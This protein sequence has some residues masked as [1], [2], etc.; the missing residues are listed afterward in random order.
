MPS[1]ETISTKEQWYDLTQ[2]KSEIQNFV[3]KKRQQLDKHS[4]MQ[5]VSDALYRICYSGSTE[6]ERERFPFAAELFKVYK[7]ALIESSL[8][9]YSALVEVNGEDAQNVLKAPKV[10]EA[11]TL[12]LKAMSM[13]EKISGEVLD[14]WCFKGE[15]AGIIKL[16]DTK[17][18]YRVK[19]EITNEE[20]GQKEMTFK[21]KE[22]VEYQDIGIDFIDPLDLYIDGLDYEKDPVGCTKIIRSFIDAKKL[23]S[24]NAYPLLTK[25]DKE[26]II[27]G[28]GRNGNGTN[29]PWF[30]WAGSFS[31]VSNS[32]EV[33]DKNQIEVLTFNGDYVTSDLKVLNNIQAVLVGNRIAN[34]RYNTVSTNRIIYAAYKLDRTTHRSISPLAV[35]LPTNKLVN[36]VTDMFIKNLDEVS[37]PWL[38]YAKGTMNSNQIAEARRKRELEY[39]PSDEKPTFWSPPPAANNGLDLVN[40]ILQQNKNVLGLNNYMAGDTSGA[41]RTA[42]ESS[43]LFQKAN[44]R[45]RVETD[46]FSYRFM[47]KL[48]QSFYAFNRELALAYD[49]PLKEIYSDP[50]L[51][52]TISTNA[53]KADKEGELQRLLQMLNLPIA[54]MIFANL[55]P[56][57][58]VLAVRYL[59]SKAGLT[60]M[61]NLLQLQKED[62]SPEDVMITPDPSVKEM[63]DIIQNNNDN[64]NMNET[65]DV[66]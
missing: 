36:R 5:K 45:M 56:D 50:D 18:E 13:L 66:Q 26:A 44:A 28:V 46:T 11:M 37:N 62:G 38:L 25:D 51:K 27:T 23:L 15:A 19:A 22:G 21:L 54:Q 24:S 17:E 33:S 3:I 47:L 59:M 1:D 57:Q 30:N 2:Y 49:N 43:I 4:N 10:K 9:G 12:Q 41:V 32:Y 58:V 8:S 63:V 31:N 65:T 60:D 64:I 14:D 61:D 7:T 16:V 29:N 53:S 34:L 52:V 39:N 48:F 42:E 20:T 40:L 6:A 55:Q 35:T